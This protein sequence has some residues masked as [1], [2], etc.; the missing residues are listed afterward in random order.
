[1]TLN[2]R[3]FLAAG[4]ALGT[5]AALAQPTSPLP[6]LINLQS[7]PL[8]PKAS[9]AQ[10]GKRVVICG[11]G[12]GG[13][14]AAKYLRKLDPSLDVVLLERNPVFFSCPMSNKWLVDVVDAQFLTHSYLPVAQKY[15]YTFIQTEV[16]AFERDQKRVITA[17]GWIDYDYLIIGAGIRY[18]YEAWFGNDRK[19]ADYTKAMF[20]AA[21]IPNAEHFRLKQSIQN[22]TGGDLVMT[23]PPPPH[24][25][26]PSP[27]ERACLIA[28]LFKQRKIKGKV[29]ILDPKDSPRPIT[30]GFQEAFEN[31]Y[32]DQI[33]YVPKAVIKEVDPFNKQIKT[34]AGDFKFDHSILMAPHQAGDMVW[35]AGVIGKN[36]EGKNTGWA[37]VDPFFLNVKNDPD[38]YVIGDAVGAV[39]PQFNFYPKAGHVANAHARIVAK[40]IVE[41]VKGRTPKYDL[42]DNLCF[43]M[44]NTEPREDVAVRFKYWVNEKGVIIQDQDDDNLRRDELVTEDFQWYGRMVEDMFG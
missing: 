19:A 37:D 38:V 44:V 30:G 6:F 4:A 20:P 10:S 36:A 29:I 25:C 43:M 18:G 42:P 8:L 27:Y 40:Y 35:K 21:Y 16:T 2:R 9:G 41:R 31:L 28:G 7:S 26:P 34:S 12:W 39:S 17:Q 11:G 3:Q 1:M 14:T 5:T 13:V 33:V 32:K 23:L 22:F 15:G 24:R